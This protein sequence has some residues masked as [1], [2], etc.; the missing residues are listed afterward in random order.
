MTAELLDEFGSDLEAVFGL[1][2]PT[3]EQTAEVMRHTMDRSQVAA[4]V[5]QSF[6][7]LGQI[8]VEVAAELGRASILLADWLHLREGMLLELNQPV[9]DSIDLRFNGVLKGQG[10]L[11]VVD[12]HLGVQVSA[13]DL[14]AT[15]AEET[16]GERT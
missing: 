3:D 12:N 4:I 5:E 8:Q 1:I 7:E 2:K 13:L 11:S 15:D 9:G 14:T 10:R 16:E 6:G